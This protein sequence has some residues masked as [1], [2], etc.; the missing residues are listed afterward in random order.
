MTIQWVTRA[1]WRAARSS[2]AENATPKHVYGLALHYTGTDCYEDSHAKCVAQVRGIQRH[3]QQSRGWADI[4]YSFLICQHGFVFVGRGTAAGPA[5]QGTQAGNLHFWGVCYLGGPHDPFSKPAQA[6]LL[7]LRK[8]LMQRGAGDALR[9]HSQFVPTSCPGKAV[10]KW[11]DSWVRQWPT[12]AN[13]L[14]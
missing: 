4:A 7:G 14:S 5:S 12:R 6:A 8:Y 13:S 10:T 11:R 2:G 3:H 1:D 9:L